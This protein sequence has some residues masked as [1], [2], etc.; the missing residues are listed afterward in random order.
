VSR[1]KI[2]Q[3]SLHWMIRRTLLG[4]RLVFAFKHEN[5][6]LLDVTIPLKN[7]FTAGIA[8]REALESFSEVFLNHSYE[9]VL[10]SD[11]CP[12]NILD[13]G[14]HHGFF[15]LWLASSFASESLSCFMIDG[16]SRVKV[17]ID[18]LRSLNPSMR[19]FQFRHGA[20]SDGTGK[21]GF[22]RKSGMGSSPAVR[23]NLTSPQDDSVDI[24]DCAEILQIAPP[25]YDLVK[26]D[27]EGWETKFIQ[28]YKPVIQSAHS[29]LIEWHSW[30]QDQWTQDDFLSALNEFAF[31][32]ILCLEKRENVMVEGIAQSCA[33]YWA[34]RT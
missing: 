26:V 13:I 14:C 15:S 20:I 1:K 34:R 2:I 7:G 17:S 4:R 10:S 28:H 33:V 6:D 8:S 12:R 24:V 27:I 9:P 29:L 25:P 16:D 21:I 3:Q 5:F 11:F 30:N 18:R 31:S 19:G 23:E 22:T 32:S